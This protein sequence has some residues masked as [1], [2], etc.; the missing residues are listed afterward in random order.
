MKEGHEEGSLCIY[1]PS[2]Y[3][4]SNKHS[5]NKRQAINSLG[6]MLCPLNTELFYFPILFS[7][8][9]QTH[10]RRISV[11]ACGAGVYDCFSN[12]LFLISP[13]PALWGKLCSVIFILMFFE[14]G[15]KKRVAC[16]LS[17][18]T[19]CGAVVTK[20]VIQLPAGKREGFIYSHLYT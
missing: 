12:R 15:S 7:D 10:K 3:I 11:M 19:F 18:K 1:N 13:V 6:R 20:D 4:N 8:R 9:C 5:F 2:I 17:C 14:I 16:S